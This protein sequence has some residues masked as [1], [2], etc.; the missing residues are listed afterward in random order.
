MKV[1]LTEE[2]IR[3]ALHESIDEMILEEELLQEWGESF[4]KAWNGVKNA[5]AMYMD[6]RTNGQWNRKYGIR[7]NGNTKTGELYY[8]NKWFNYYKEKLNDIIYKANTPD[9]RDEYDLWERD[10]NNPNKETKKINRY[11]YTG[12]EG[13]LN[14]AKTYCTPQN[15]N[16]YIKALNPDRESVWHINTYIQNYITKQ[17]INNNLKAVLNNLNIATFYSSNVFKQ[18]LA[19]N[20]QKQQEK[21]KQRRVNNNSN[22]PVQPFNFDGNRKDKFGWFLGKDANGKNIRIY[23]NDT[24]QAEFV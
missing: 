8:L 1:I 4:K 23:P 18:Y 17:A 14:Y 5:A 21:E 7:V 19:M 24:S 3:K 13:A 22:Q 11:D 2:T 9:R 16:D 6:W 15:F 20:R 10:P 12:I